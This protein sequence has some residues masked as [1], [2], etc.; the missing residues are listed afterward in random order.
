[1]S[2]LV[3][4]P[5][6]RHL[7]VGNPHGARPTRGTRPDTLRPDPH[8]AARRQPPSQHTQH[9]FG[10]GLR[11][12]TRLPSR[13]SRR[14]EGAIETSQANSQT[15]LTLASI[16]RTSRLDRRFHSAGRGATKERSRPREP[17]L[18]PGS[19][20]P[21]SPVPRASTGGSVPLVEARR[22]SDRDLASRSSGPVSYKHLT[23]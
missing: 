22:R 3:P 10:V 16:A 4:P 2:L 17:I 23:L 19:P 1:M 7:R 18:R 14:D 11:P 5:H 12:A 8:L 21:R 6:H 13:W 15:R 9:C 20:W